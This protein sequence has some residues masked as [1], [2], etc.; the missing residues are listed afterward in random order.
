MRYCSN[1]VI[2]CCSRVLLLAVMACIVTSCSIATGNIYTPRTPLPGQGLIYIYR[3][4]AFHGGAYS[5]PFIVNG[6]EKLKVAN[7]GYCVYN[8]KPG[9]TTFSLGN[10][11]AGPDIEHI[12]LYVEPDEVYY[13]RYSITSSLFNSMRMELVDSATGEA[14]IKNLRMTE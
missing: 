8:A 7:G 4:P 11:I 14:E 1:R 2:Q 13:V 12:T 10:V 3:P 5:W 9:N 6:V